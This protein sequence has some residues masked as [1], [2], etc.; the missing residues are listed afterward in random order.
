MIVAHIASTG[1]HEGE[2]DTDRLKSMMKR[3]PR[4]YSEISSLTQANKP[5]Y[6]KEALR[7][8]VFQGRLFYGSDYPLI[9]TLLVS[10]WYFQRNL[11]LS[12]MKTISEIQNPWDRD[13]ALKQAL[14]VPIEVFER[15]RLLLMSPEDFDQQK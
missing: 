10:P 3:Y 13:V 7:D 12:Q 15:A 2:R 14:G 1:Q 9:N 8:E 6:L 11:K 4:L 5:G